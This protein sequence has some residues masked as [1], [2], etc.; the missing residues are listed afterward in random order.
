MARFNESGFIYQSR[1][2][3]ALDYLEK[4]ASHPQQSSAEGNPPA[5][6]FRKTVAGFHP[7]ARQ[8]V[9]RVPRVEGTVEGEVPAGG[10]PW[11]ARAGTYSR[12]NRLYQA[13]SGFSRIR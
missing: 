4:I 1:K 2:I 10:T 5:R 8:S 6:L 3:D 11:L 12:K 7:V 9:A 13:L